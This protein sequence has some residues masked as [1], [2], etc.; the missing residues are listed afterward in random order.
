MTDVAGM[1]ERAVWRAMTKVVADPAN[2]C[3]MWTGRVEP[4]G[5]PIIEE[6]RDHRTT[7]RLVARL[8]YE[9]LCGP[10]PTGFNLFRDPQRC[11]HRA[12]VN[13]FHVCPMDLKESGRLYA[14]GHGR[15][16]QGE[17][18]RACGEVNWYLDPDGSRKCRTC[19]NRRRRK[20]YAERKRNRAVSSTV[21]RWPEP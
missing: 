1:S 13:P 12:C 18:C 5:Y 4:E 15:P 7:T 11:P 10:I 2:G 17:N 6:T 19:R 3:W 8:I 21:L 16:S 9:A 20:V 14:L